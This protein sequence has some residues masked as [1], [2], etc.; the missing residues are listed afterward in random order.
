MV[1]KAVAIA[2]GNATA[3]GVTPRVIQG[4]VTRLSELGVGD[5]Y[6]LLL[7]VGCFHT[8]PEDQRPAYVTSV[9]HAAAP[10]GTLL[11]YGFRRPPKAAPM[12]AGVTPEEVQQRFSPAGWHL[13]TAERDSAADIPA[14]PRAVDRFELWRYQLQRAS[15]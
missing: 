12:H 1:A 3:A 8:L 9:S 11:L 2:R 5:G 14:V 10:G 6:T 7:D 15:T 13:V 4:D